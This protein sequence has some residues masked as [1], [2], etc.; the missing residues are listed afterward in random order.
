MR[1]LLLPVFFWFLVVS[2]LTPVLSAAP[3]PQSAENLEL[4]SIKSRLMTDMFFAG[5]LADAIMEIGIQNRFISL[6]GEED[7]AQIRAKLILWIRSHPDSA[8]G[9]FFHVKKRPALPEQVLPGQKSIKRVWWEVNPH[10]LA[11]IKDLS[12]SVRS[13]DISREELSVS[14]RRIFEGLS[15]GA[16]TVV[17]GSGSDEEGLGRAS[18]FFS[19]PPLDWKLDR[20]GIVKEQKQ[21]SRWLSELISEFRRDQGKGTPELHEERMV[22]LELASLSLKDFTV[23][24][25]RLAGRKGMSESES[26]SLEKS[27]LVLRMA[28]A[29]CHALSRIDSIESK[30]RLIETA[31]VGAPA[32]LAGEVKKKYAGLGESLRLEGKAIGARYRLVFSRLKSAVGNTLLSNAYLEL[33]RLQEEELKSSTR[34]ALYV[35]L[36]RLG[37]EIANLDRALRGCLLDRIMYAFVSRLY[38]DSPHVGMRKELERLKKTIP[39]AV[40][41]I[42]R[43]D[44]ARALNLVAGRR[45]PGFKGEGKL[46]LENVKKAAGQA[47]FIIKSIRQAVELNKSI[48]FVFW[49]AFL[50]PLDLTFYVEKLLN[51]KK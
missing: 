32:W 48:Q 45:I 47:D 11:M 18:R 17:D 31:L 6:S 20:R 3:A 1:T 35:E 29:R 30:S 38:P 26:R 36:A 21:T 43:A 46:D 12:Q 49:D 39:A 13:R 8:A 14:G 9:I 50:S 4:D 22:S 44:Y 7:R 42:N 40:R 19:F 24:S 28:L 34:L 16:G 2:G 33:S 23:R 27:R 51:L 25:S 5:E 10:F 37:K 41:E 15:D